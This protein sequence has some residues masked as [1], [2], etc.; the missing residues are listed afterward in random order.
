[1][2]NK[3]MTILCLLFLVIIIPFVNGCKEKSQDKIIIGVIS[4]NHPFSIIDK[5]NELIGYDIDLS[6]EFGRYLNKEIEFKKYAS[7]SDIIS[8]L[9]SKQIDVVISSLTITE[10]RKEIID[11]SD[12]YF[13]N[14]HCILI[15]NNSTITKMEEL[16]EESKIISV[17]HG[18]SSDITATHMFPNATIKK[19]NGDVPA[20]LELLNQKTDA[21]LC[22][23]TW[24]YIYYLRHSDKVR[25]LVKDI[26]EKQLAGIVLYKNNMD[27]LNQVNSF[28][29]EYKGSKKE[30]DSY[31]KWFGNNHWIRLI[32]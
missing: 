12:P 7:V 29:K 16:N 1:M 9:Q 25:I 24:G 13:E 26:G 18:T 11:F 14:Y 31:E 4:E 15:N 20:G 6:K 22:D 8:G 5:N 32:N 28:L 2:K 10:K 21:F 3:L 17:N 23:N 19:F 30:R 27:L